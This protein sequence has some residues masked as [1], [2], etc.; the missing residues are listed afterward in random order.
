[1]KAL[2]IVDVQND[3][4]PGGTLAT[5][6]GDTIIPTINQLAE[7]FPLVVAS[8]DWHPEETV[9]FEKWP[10]HCVE[11]TFGAEYDTLLEHHKIHHEFL[12]GTDPNT[13]SGYS[14]FEATSKNLDEFLREK[15]VTE[16]YIVGIATE[17]CVKASALDALK[18]GYKTFVITDAISPVFPEDAPAALQAM[19]EQNAI[20]LGSHEILG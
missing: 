19:Q 15:G 3:F 7:K 10:P 13:D 16:L 2:L 5:E 6:Q 14:A 20:L 9:H 18:L 12:K 4:T 8:R 17:Y 1:M 11:S